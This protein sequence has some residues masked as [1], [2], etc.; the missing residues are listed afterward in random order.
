MN[1][2]LCL[3]DENG[4]MK[5][6]YDYAEKRFYGQHR[7]VLINGRV[8]NTLSPDLIQI[9][10]EELI[11]DILERTRLELTFRGGC[12]LHILVC[13]PYESELGKISDQ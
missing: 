7:G 10:I 9:I 4:H 3:L 5:Q 2:S 1:V 8:A 6:I 13:R 12:K 11:L